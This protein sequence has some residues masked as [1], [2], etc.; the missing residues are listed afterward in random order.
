MEFPKHGDFSIEVDGR[1]V[2]SELVGPWNIETAREYIHQLDTVVA[3][4]L[5]GQR[6]GS[7]V[8]C[9]ESIQFPLD[10]I[11]PLRASVQRRVAQFDQA[12]V[13][14]VVAPDVEGYRLLYPPIRS[15]Y[16]GLVPFDIFDTRNDADA[17]MARM[18]G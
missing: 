18:L 11:A 14:M 8:V 12:A 3:E 2:T 1:I 16:D 10:M 13:A 17:W 4:R 15:I 7:V 9:R 5:A 6:W